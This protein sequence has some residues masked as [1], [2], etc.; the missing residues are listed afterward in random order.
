MRNYSEVKLTEF[1][2]ELHRHPEL[3][4][5]EVQTAIRISR[6]LAAQSPDRLITHLGGTG[7]AAVFEGP[8]PPLPR[9][10]THRHTH[11]DK[12]ARYRLVG[13]T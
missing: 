7:I 4:G 9:T 2:R 10:H 6:F 12:K 11:T 5:E 8:P 3:S 13:L 1:R